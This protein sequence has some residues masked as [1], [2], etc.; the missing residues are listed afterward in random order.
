MINTKIEFHLQK[1][2]DLLLPKT[3]AKD[4]YHY[5][6]FPTGKLF[7][8]SLVW[9]ILKDLNNSLY[10]DSHDKAEASHS[11]LASSI[12]FHHAYTL[13]HDDLPSMDD[14]SI[15]RGK[16][17][18]HLAFNEWKALLTGDGLLILSFHLLSKIKNNRMP[19]LLAFYTWA[20]GPK[21]LIQGQYLDLSH[22]P[23]INLN[24]ILHIHELK[25]ARLIQ[26]AI[27][28]SASLAI[29]KNSQLEKSLWKY[30]KL[31]GINFQ[32]LDDLSELSE[33]LSEHEKKINPWFLFNQE[34][35][36]L[37]T[38][39]LDKFETLSAELK[40]IETREIVKTYYEKMI[41]HFENNLNLD[42]DIL[43]IIFR[44]KRFCK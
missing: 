21:G 8:A 44:L 26:T 2:L 30:S 36:N 35:I 14:D 5:A 12:E 38:V 33:T 32:L 18:A 22:D 42:F 7:R 34:T 13:L 41:F 40:L 43:P 1:H 37:L 20:T 3:S 19:E 25:T 27:L 17:C 15:R 31:L 23:L 4:V 39:N 9:S 11:L 10:L 28:G 29:K 16:P 6:I 24:S